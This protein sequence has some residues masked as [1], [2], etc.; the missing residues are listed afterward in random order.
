MAWR[1]EIRRLETRLVEAR[2]GFATENQARDAGERA[3]RVIDRIS[4]PNQETLTT[5]VVAR[6]AGNGSNGHPETPSAHEDSID[7]ASATQDNGSLEYP[8]QQPVRAVLLE[9]HPQNLPQ[10]IK[11]ADRAI[12][13][14]LRDPAPFELDE[15]FALGQALLALR[16][17]LLDRI[18]SSEESSETEH[19][20]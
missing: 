8:W 1:Y 9:Q 5:T 12:S 16:S 10:K 6:E 11:V 14:R 18:D 20:S 2:S 17:V 19:R 3:K 15:R 4:Y 7:F 13:A